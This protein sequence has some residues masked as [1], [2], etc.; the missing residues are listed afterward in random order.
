MR[1][2][3]FFFGVF[4]NINT[5]LLYGK[6]RI[7][8][9]SLTGYADDMEGKHRDSF[10]SKLFVVY[11]IDYTQLHAQ[12]LKYILISSTTDSRLS[13]PKMKYKQFY[14]GE[15]ERYVRIF[16]GYIYTWNALR[17]YTF[18]GERVYALL[19]KRWKTAIEKFW[20]NIKV[21]L[22]YI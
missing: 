18:Y 12:C 15:T 9:Y 20:I 5:Q 16:S 14:F 7:L 13:L 10:I 1:Y 2:T 19:E 22:V 21:L 8:F 4:I 6:L 17:L 11:G 3:I